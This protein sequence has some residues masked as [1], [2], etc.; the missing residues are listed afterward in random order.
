MPPGLCAPAILGNGVPRSHKSPSQAL[1]DQ[2]IRMH[3]DA[4]AT[5]QC[6]WPASPLSVCSGGSHLL[7]SP[8]ARRTC[9]LPEPATRS[10][11]APPAPHPPLSRP[12][13][14]ECE[15]AAQMWRLVPTRVHMSSDALAVPSHGPAAHGQLVS[16]VVE[17][18]DGQLVP[19]GLECQ[20]WPSPNCQTACTWTSLLQP[21]VL[22]GGWVGGPPKDLG[23]TRP[24]RI[25][26][27]CRGDI[28][29]SESKMC[30]ALH[31][32]AGLTYV[33]EGHP[34]GWETPSRPRIVITGAGQPVPAPSGFSSNGQPGRAGAAPPSTVSLG[35][36][37]TQQVPWAGGLRNQCWPV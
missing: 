6:A 33:L 13:W 1:A 16:R 9:S 14:S 19:A 8:K 10:G 4:Y 17:R 20:R 7:S 37:G 35:P 18:C 21:Q 3:P 22:R 26:V 32:E 2:R 29:T 12:R 31:A 5:Q 30:A 28:V 15:W 24:W 27:S 23:R 34:D 11:M 36:P 25:W